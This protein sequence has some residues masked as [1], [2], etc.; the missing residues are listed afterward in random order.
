MQRL[1]QLSNLYFSL[2]ML[3]ISADN[4]QRTLSDIAIEFSSFGGKLLIIDEIH[5]ATNSEVCI[6]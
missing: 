4:V 6:A 1:I 2:K 5:K 3:Y